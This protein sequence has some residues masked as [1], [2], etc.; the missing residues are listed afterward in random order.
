LRQ[1]FAPAWLPPLDEAFGITRVAE[2]TGLD[3]IGVPVVSVYR[4]LS[5]SLSIAQGKGLSNGQAHV[6]G[7][8]EC[9]EVWHAERPGGAVIT[10]ASWD[11]ERGRIAHVDPF[12]LPV[13][14]RGG[15]TRYRPVRWLRGRA[16][17]SGRDVWV[18][19]A[20]VDTN[21]AGPAASHETAMFF[22][23]TTGLASATTSDAALAHA[24]CEVV[25][26]DS[27]ARWLRAGFGRVP[28]TGAP[29]P[30]WTAAVGLYERLRA[31][32]IRAMTWEPPCPPGLS[33]FYVA[34]IDGASDLLLRQP[35]AAG[36]ACH[37]SP[38]RAWVDATLEAI[39]A[40]ATRISGCREDL[41]A[42]SQDCIEAMS[43][44][45]RRQADASGTAR[46][47]V[48]ENQATHSLT[49]IL[50]AMAGSTLGEPVAV[51]LSPADRSYHVVRVVVPRAAVPAADPAHL[52]QV[53]SGAA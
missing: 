5:R 41:P 35:P 12:D 10:G 40:R 38:E 32:E 23:T 34:L 14:V 11:L 21:Y 20:M 6:S 47:C 31:C 30:H 18:P 27:V 53:G 2:I 37:T 8:M 52:L 39:C 9:V 19:H 3:R 13:D 44:W 28:S 36:S 15:L 50:D 33:C 25:E 1:V 48:R 51:D 49:S 29:P 42:M 22:A 43:E 4:P 17:R 24:L 16:L 45:F 46:S 7:I 26:R